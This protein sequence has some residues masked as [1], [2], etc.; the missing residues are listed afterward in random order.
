MQ[1]KIGF[2]GMQTQIEFMN[3]KDENEIKE[4]RKKCI[5]PQSCV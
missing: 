2:N 1:V 5:L 4:S 3:G